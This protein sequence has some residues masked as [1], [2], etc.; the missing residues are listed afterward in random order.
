MTSGTSSPPLAGVASRSPASSASHPAPTA[1]VFPRKLWTGSGIARRDLGRTYL[2]GT[3]HAFGA[4]RR[5]E[6]DPEFPAACPTGRRLRACERRGRARHSGRRCGGRRHGRIRGCGRKLKARARPLQPRHKPSGEPKA[7][8]LAEDNPPRA[9]PPRQSALDRGAVR[10]GWR[11]AAELAQGVDALFVYAA[12]TGRSRTRELRR[13]VRRA[14]RRGRGAR[15]PVFRQPGRG[16]AIRDRSTEARRRGLWQSRLNSVAAHLGE[17]DDVK[18]GRRMIRPATP[19]CGAA[20]AP[21]CSPPCRPATASS[22]ACIPR[23]AHR[24]ASPRRGRAAARLRQRYSGRDRPGQCA[25]PGRAGGEPRRVGRAA[26]GG[27]P[28]GTVGRTADPPDPGL[29]AGRA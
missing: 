16:A 9:R 1:R 20:G 12:T 28:R 17:P 29:A 2:A 11:G 5:G 26:G 14:P 21:A 13:R 25:D 23:R 7:R 3:S 6:A 24:R 15:T 18:G 10:H 8:A 19:R 4:S 27:G 22:C